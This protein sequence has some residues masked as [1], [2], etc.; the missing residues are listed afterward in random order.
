MTRMTFRHW[1]RAPIQTLLQ[2]VMLSLGIAVFF[3]IRLANNAAV[4]SFEHF[5][6]LLHA[7]SDYEIKP[8]EGKIPVNLLK[9]LRDQLGAIPVDLV[10]ILE[11][12]ATEPIPRGEKKNPHTLFQLLGLD[13]I[14]LGNLQSSTPLED[15]LFTQEPKISN[16]KQLFITHAFALEKNLKPGDSLPLVIHDALLDFQV[17]GL[18]PDNPAQPKIPPHLLLIDLPDLQEITHQQGKLSKIQCI[19][20]SGSFHGAK[21]L[22]ELQKKNLLEHLSPIID[23]RFEIVTSRDERAQ[24]AF[25]TQA[26]RMNLTI[27]SLVA[28]MAGLYLI[29]QALDGAVVRRRGEIA[30]LRS[31]GVSSR[32]IQCHWIMEALLLGICGGIFGIL[33]GWGGAQLAIRSVGAIVNALYFSTTIDAASFDLHELFL[34]MLLAITSSLLTGW[35]PAREAAQTPPAQILSHEY[36]QK[37]PR[38]IFQSITVASLLLVSSA[39]LSLAPAVTFFHNTHLPLCGYLA[40][41]FLILGAGIVSAC[42]TEKLG[43]LIALLGTFSLVLRLAASHLRPLSKRHYLAACGILSG[44]IMAA[45]MLILIASFETTMQRWIGVVFQAD[46][47]ISSAD[48]QG[49]NLGH[50][51]SREIVSEIAQGPGIAD[52]ELITSRHISLKGLPTMISEIDVGFLERHHNILWKKAP[53]NHD[54]FDEKKNSHLVLASESFLE[55]FDYHFGDHVTIPTPTGNQDMTIAGVFSDYGNEQG[56]LYLAAQDHELGLSRYHVFND[57][58]DDL[59]ELARIFN[60]HL[61]R[62]PESLMDATLK[63]EVFLGQDETYSRRQTSSL[64]LPH[65]PSQSPRHNQYEISGLGTVL[66]VILEPQVDPEIVRQ[67]LNSRFPGLSIFTN[68]TLREEILRIFHQ[69]FSITYALELIGIMVA[70]IGL[71]MTFSNILMDRTKEL[72]TLRTLGCTSHTM[73]L[74][75]ALEGGLLAFSATLMGIIASLGMG[76]ILIY[77]INKQSFGWTLQFSFPYLPL[78]LL[79]IAVILSGI[80]VAY[81]VASKS[82]YLRIEL[83]E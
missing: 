29:L 21:K 28:L 44:V 32:M 51:L 31:L 47:Y 35:F 4:S 23:G 48:Y 56:V 61:L 68:R 34:A 41:L 55:R 37:R 82:G 65:P 54:F 60:T 64:A 39:L 1:R 74:A 27:L 42:V 26:F 50:P 16:K 83:H 62:R 24:A 70:M 67:E 53:L 30:L 33:L 52:I 75:T 25:M 20:A 46:L 11:S 49:V 43:K 38:G 6:T 40:T 13:L 9:E 22:R 69:T 10:P 81:Q 3:S 36:D 7:E 72:T 63:L 58:H 18:I 73:A 66:I 79:A 59:P 76:Y 77:V 15:V 14:A 8:H 19:L 80:A 45:G 5:S 12:S 57:L 17:A 71:G 78:A 2:V